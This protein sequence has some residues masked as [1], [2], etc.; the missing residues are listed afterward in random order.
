M[1]NKLP[2]LPLK[3]RDIFFSINRRYVISAIITIIWCMA[4]LIA[5]T[6][7]KIG[8]NYITGTGAMIAT[9]AV[10]I[11]LLH[12]HKV[13][14]DRSWTGVVKSVV[15]DNKPQHALLGGSWIPSPVVPVITIQIERS[16]GKIITKQY[17]LKKDQDHYAEALA[18]YYNAG[19]LVYSY[20]G[21]KYLKKEDNI[22]QFNNIAHRLC[23][24]CGNF[25][26]WEYTE[27][28]NCKSTFVD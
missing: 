5:I 15:R 3:N 13:I 25:G 6:V 14:F 10:P 20:K 17:K 8:S 1:K 2:I 27:C 26:D 16:D 28:R 23:I 9:I 21:T 24:V 11:C 4:V 22:M 18:A 7:Y 19:S 12:P